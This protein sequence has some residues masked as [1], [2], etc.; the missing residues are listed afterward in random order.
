MNV[1]LSRESVCAGDDVDAPHSETISF[2]DGTSVLDVL[3]Q[4]ARSG[5][6]ASIVG[7]EATWSAVSNV[8]LA[9]IAQQWSKPKP[10]PALLYSSADL[11]VKDNTLRIH[12]N[13]HA[14]E[15]PDKVYKILYGLRLR[16]I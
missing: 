3:T 1:Y 14:Q 4:V 2:P 9:V 5:Y 8:P 6:L 12:F 11:D 10:L 16:A 15:N 13:Y 7:G